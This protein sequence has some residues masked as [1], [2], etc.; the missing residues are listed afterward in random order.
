[1]KMNNEKPK[2]DK[3][4]MKIIDLFC[5]LPQRKRDKLWEEFFKTAPKDMSFTEFLKEK[6]D[7]K[8]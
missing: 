6:F 3:E 7:R 4:Y 2:N 1:M 5:R 8:I